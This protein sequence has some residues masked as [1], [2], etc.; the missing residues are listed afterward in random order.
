KS[1][2]IAGDSQPP[3]VHALV[4][5]MNQ[6]LGN[7]G[8]TVFYSEPVEA[9]PVEQT[10][11]LRELIDAMKDG[12]VD[13]LISIGGNPVFT[14]PADLEFSAHAAKVPLRIHHSLYYDETAALSH[15]HIPE[16]YYLEAWGDARA[17]D[18]TTSII[19]P[20]IN[21]L[22]QSKSAYELLS[23]LLG[24]PTRSN[25]EIVQGY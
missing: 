14:T 10:Q 5:E 17:Y 7:V 9:N 1:I 16:T 4:H 2:V 21:P 3:D 6:R 13:T 25:Y 15:W 24:D 8:Q 20:L 19:Q 18:G 22:Y 11:S 23:A 12:H